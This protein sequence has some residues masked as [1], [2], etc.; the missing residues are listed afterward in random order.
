MHGAEAK[1][2]PAKK[3]KSTTDAKLPTVRSVLSEIKEN[4]GP[5]AS[6]NKQDESRDTSLVEIGLD[7][8]STELTKHKE[9]SGY[10]RERYSVADLGTEV[11]R[12][13]TVYSLLKRSFI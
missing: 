5:G 13:K 2:P 9:L 1:P 12:M 7:I 3:I 8:A 10:Q 4:Y 11:I 6:T